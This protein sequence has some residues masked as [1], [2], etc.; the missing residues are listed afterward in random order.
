[1]FCR[2][3][4]VVSVRELF[5][6]STTSGTRSP[7]DVPKIA[8][9]LRLSLDLTAQNLRPIPFMIS[10]NWRS[11]RSESGLEKVASD[12]RDDHPAESSLI[13]NPIYLLRGVRKTCYVG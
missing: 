3:D 8:I 7:E 11:S 12:L 9:S 4:R 6:I 10:F 1:M 13:G 2:N 5:S